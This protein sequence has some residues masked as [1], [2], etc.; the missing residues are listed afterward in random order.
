MS[1]NLSLGARRQPMRFLKPPL[2]V[3]A[4]PAHLPA[5]NVCGGRS[6]PR[7]PP[8][9]RRPLASATHSPPR[10][11]RSRLEIYIQSIDF[12]LTEEVVGNKLGSFHF[13]G[14]KVALSASKTCPVQVPP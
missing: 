8:S 10:H 7:P 5:G 11:P 3:P 9:P 14:E 13:R 12:G 6:L 4:W 2:V 1:N